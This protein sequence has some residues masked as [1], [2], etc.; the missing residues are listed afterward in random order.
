MKEVDGTQREEIKLIVER[1]LP[2]DG[3]KKILS[4]FDKK[5]ILEQS[6]SEARRL[7]E[8][9][10]SELSVFPPSPERDEMF[11]LADYALQRQK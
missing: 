4:L 1:G 7:I 3:L 6:L 5:N 2:E 8:E 9:A 11:A 10:K